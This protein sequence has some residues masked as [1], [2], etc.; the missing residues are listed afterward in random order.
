MA[1]SYDGKSL[2]IANDA[3]LALVIGERH[4]AEDRSGH[5]GEVHADR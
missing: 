4:S 2:T 3:P 1:G 5:E